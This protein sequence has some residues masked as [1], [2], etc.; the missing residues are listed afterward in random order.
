M[1]PEVPSTE[2]RN[3]RML[4]AIVF[5][6]GV[7]FSARMSAD[8]EHTLK[9]IDRDLSLM[10]TLCTQNEGRV[11]KSTG[12]G[13]LMCFTS[14]VQAVSCALEIQQSLNQSAAQLPHHDV[15]VHRI[16]I[17]LG[18]VFFRD[19]DVMGNGVNIAARLESKAEPG[20]VCISKTVFDV[21]KK[22]LNLT[23]HYLGELVL[24]NIEDP[25]PAYNLQST[26]TAIQDIP[27]SATPASAT[28]ASATLDMAIGSVVANRYKVIQPLG[29]GGF[30]RTYLVADSQ[31][32]DEWLVLKEFMPH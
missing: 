6:D 9:L 17:H 24:K 29:E 20:G 18:D 1:K 3:Q 11:L 22:Q 28:S 4:A 27:A 16:G 7:N 14:A 10:R 15:L 13:L 25:I 32:F 23:A 30:G 31:R 8:E 5:T 2:N 19:G 12:D 21:V 26:D